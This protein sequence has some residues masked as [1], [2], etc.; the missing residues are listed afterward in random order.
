M[1]AD[2]THKDSLRIATNQPLWPYHRER[3][4]NFL[5]QTEKEQSSKTRTP[6]PDFYS[7]IVSASKFSMYT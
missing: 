1:L 5:Q 4:Y 3:S 2:K 6:G 7:F